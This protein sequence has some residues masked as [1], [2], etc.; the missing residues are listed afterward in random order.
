M[1]DKAVPQEAKALPP[2]RGR[3]VY[4]GPNMPGG[5]LQRFSVFKGGVPPYVTELVAACPEAQQLI[6][7]TDEL[8]ATRAAI[9]VRGTA[10]NLAYCAM[11]DY[12]TGGSGK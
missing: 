6:V 7:P 11:M 1:S 10:A 2:A 3:V 9:E 4:C 12:F 5:L 8:A